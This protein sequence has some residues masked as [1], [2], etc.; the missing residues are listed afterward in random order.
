VAEGRDPQLERWVVAACI[1]YAAIFTAA[2]VATVP[3]LLA[4]ESGLMLRAQT[5]SLVDAAGAP[6]P[7]WLFRAADLLMGN[8]LLGAIAFRY[9]CVA[10][11]FILVFR[12]ALATLGRSDLAALATGSLL[13]SYG[14]AVEMHRDLLPGVLMLAA[15]AATW[16][17]LVPI[18]LGRA[19][20]ARFAV[21]GVAVGLGRLAAATPSLV[22]ASALVLVVASDPRARARC[23]D[24]R[25]LLALAVAA[26]LVL[27]AGYSG[28]DFVHVLPH[29]STLDGLARY[30]GGVVLAALPVALFW[31]LLLRGGASPTP[32]A[33]VPAPDGDD[34]LLERLLRN[35][36]GAAL[37][38]LVAPALRA[39]N[40]EDALALPLLLPASLLV[41]ARAKRVGANVPRLRRFAWVIGA[42]ALVGLIAVVARPEIEA[43][44]CARCAALR[45]YRPA[46][47]ALAQASAGGALIVGEDREAV[48]NLM[49]WLPEARGWVRDDPPAAIPPDGPGRTCALLW[50]GAVGV[51]GASSAPPWARALVR[52]PP[53]LSL[54]QNVASPIHGLFGRGPRLFAL[55]FALAPPA[56]CALPV[57]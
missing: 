51:S 30:A 45:D 3:V 14:V 16:L 28:V 33:S 4:D 25:M 57:Q 10:A 35:W 39:G 21:L 2:R 42:G 29:G 54:V 44:T 55:S 37:A 50:G 23:A 48:A 12:A 5:L 13:L 31:A 46:A 53:G 56:A 18:L 19:T 24:R 47:Q 20:L 26:A 11:A 6:L 52:T 22:I 40:G 15:A 7:V 8:A 17:A 38:L 43:R 1:A 34:A 32:V 36:L 41:F 27:A 49:V 9:A